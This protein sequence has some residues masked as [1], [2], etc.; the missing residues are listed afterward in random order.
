MIVVRRDQ[1]AEEQVE[2]AATQALRQI[3]PG[4]VDHLDCQAEVAAERCEQLDF[5][6]DDLAGGRVGEVEPSETVPDTDAQGA[7]CA[8]FGEHI[9]AVRAVGDCEVE[10]S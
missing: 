7:A 10:L 1:C 9:A 2:L 5:E 3:H 4:R 6:A 8:C